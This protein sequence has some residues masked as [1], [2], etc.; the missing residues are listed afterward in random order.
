MNIAVKF[1][2]N[3]DLRMCIDCGFF[4]EQRICWFENGGPKM[5]QSM[6]NMNKR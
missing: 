2:F 5:A 6:K 4:G 3:K 1:N